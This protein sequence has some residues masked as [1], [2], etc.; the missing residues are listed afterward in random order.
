MF[1]RT[2]YK[3]KKNL[4]KTLYRLT[5]SCMTIIIEKHL[6]N[7]Y[8]MTGTGNIFCKYFLNKYWI[9][10]TNPLSKYSLFT[11]YSAIYVFVLI[12]PL[13]DYRTARY[14]YLFFF[15][16]KI[17]H[18]RNIWMVSKHMKRCSIHII[19]KEKQNKITIKYHYTSTRMAKIFKNWQ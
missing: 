16:L 6:L 12:G 19:I 4:S 9:L 10:T 5:S 11:W 15:F 3:I 18:K 2:N 8:Y 17:L 14:Q 7:I 13:Q 1:P